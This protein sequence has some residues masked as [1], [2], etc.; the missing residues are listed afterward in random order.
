MLLTATWYNPSPGK[1]H[2]TVSEFTY[3]AL[4]VV[5]SEVTVR[6]AYKLKMNTCIREL[7]HELIS[8]STHFI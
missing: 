4:E 8:C 7:E 2:T 1:V 3:S 5:T 6:L